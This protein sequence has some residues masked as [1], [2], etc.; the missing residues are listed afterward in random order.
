MAK[1]KLLLNITLYKGCLC[2]YKN[3]A[4]KVSLSLYLWY[5]FFSN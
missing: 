2:N 4:F 1:N 5:N 3:K